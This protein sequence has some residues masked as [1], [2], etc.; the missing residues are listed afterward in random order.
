MCSLATP[1]SSLLFGF[2]PVLP[3]YAYRGHTAPRAVRFHHFRTIV[4]LDLYQPF[5]QAAS[6]DT[7]TRFHTLFGQTTNCQATEDDWRWLQT[8]RPTCLSTVKNGHFDASKYIVAANDLRKHLNYEQPASF[9][10]VLDVR[11]CNGDNNNNGEPTDDDDIPN[12]PQA[13]QVRPAF[14]A[15]RRDGDRGER[16]GRDARRQGENNP[17]FSPLLC[18][19]CSLSNTA[20]L[21][22]NCA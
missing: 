4:K 10:P 8:C 17:L 3:L 15:S 1:R 5:R 19:L 20:S 18:R 22:P 13:M 6:N 14:T 12:H 7:Q 9:S 11:A 21:H 16:R 2:W